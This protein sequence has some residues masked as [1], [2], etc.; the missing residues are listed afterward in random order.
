MSPL[1]R[2]LTI[3]LIP[4][5]SPTRRSLRLFA[6][7]VAAAVAMPAMAAVKLELRQTPNSKS[8]YQTETK[9]EQV[10]TLGDMDIETKSTA[11]IVTSF[12]TGERAGDG[13]LSIVQKHDVLQ[14][15]LKL[16][17]IEFQFDSG[18]PDNKPSLPQLEP[19]AAVLR[20]TF[21]TPV[22]TVLES[23]GKVREVSVPEAARADLDPAFKPLFDPGK[24]KKAAEQAR[25]VLTKEPVSPG[26]AWERNA[27]VN[28]DS[29]QMLSFVN[30]F[31]YT[32]PVERDGK[33]LHRIVVKPQSV[34][35]SMAPDSPSPLKVTKSELKI[36]ESEGE[37]LFD[38]SKGLLTRDFNRVRIEGPMTFSFGGQEIPGKVNLQITKTSTLQP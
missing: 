21:T 18:N 5:R 33:M 1:L 34:T 29:G 23:D 25:D 16:Q 20:T 19:L 2:V 28:L 4:D 31:E 10:L 7:V 3:R 38:Q 35:Y 11:F 26:D 13:S 14:T 15:N 24:L 17:G 9:T 36:T 6:A 22:T 27:E 37:L 32:G 12:T 8:V 30:R